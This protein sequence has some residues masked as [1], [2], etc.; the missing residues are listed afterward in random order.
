MTRRHRATLLYTGMAIGCLAAPAASQARVSCEPGRFTAEVTSG[1]DRDLSLAGSLSF[2]VSTAG[3]LTGTLVHY[4]KRLPVTGSVHRR[5]LRLTVHLRSG[6]S[7]TGSGRA[8]RNITS[9]A[10]IPTV[11]TATGPR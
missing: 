2:T 9:C 11:G 7:M 4:G 6:R 1:P 8:T 10:R 3:R 5:S